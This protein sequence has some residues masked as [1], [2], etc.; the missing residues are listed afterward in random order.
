MKFKHLLVSVL[1]AAAPLAVQ[2]GDVAAGKAKSAGCAGCHGANGKAI[3]PNFPNLA[4]QNAPYLEQALKA[5]RSGQRTGGQAGMM[6]GMA[7]PLSDTDISD[8]AAYF[9]SL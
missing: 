9:S 2:A 3:S 6:Q 4:G 5:Y 1:I 8:L 7:G